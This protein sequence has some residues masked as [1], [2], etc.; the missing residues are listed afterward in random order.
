MTALVTGGC[1]FVGGAVVRRLVAEGIGVVSLDKLTH[2]AT[3]EAFATLP[4]DRYRLIVG[5]V[6][7]GALVRQ[8]LETHAPDMIVHCAAEGPADPPSD[9]PEDRVTANITGTFT[10]LEAARAWQTGRR[11]PFRFLHVST[12]AIFGDLGPVD[13]PF[14]EASP[15]AP[16]SPW[17]AALAAADQLVRAWGENFGAPVMT[18]HCANSFGPWQVPDRLVPKM[19]VAGIE[20]REMPVHG[21]GRQVRDWL[22][23]EDV[24][25]AI[26][27]VLQ[28]GAAGRSYAV[29]GSAEAEAIAVVR[30]ICDRLDERLPGAGGR[31]RLITHVPDRAGDAARRAVDASRIRH[32]LGWR[33]SRSFDRGLSQT[34]DWYIENTLWWRQI[35]NRDRMAAQAGEA[36][37]VRGTPGGH[38]A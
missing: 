21:N 19:I 4:E 25:S 16:G 32:E 14:N 27:A 20:G 10:L 34:V 12:D 30:R 35:R 24:A 22:H 31:R 28:A 37:D 26:W 8:V 38:A 17:A 15:L 18:V 23:V 2:A 1:G 9:G 3:P 33:P 36:S 6:R 11:G 29:G 5:D 13:P 7:D